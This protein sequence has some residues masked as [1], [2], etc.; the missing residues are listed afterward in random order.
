MAIEIINSSNQTIQLTSELQSKN[1]NK[2][3]TGFKI[4][5]NTDA[6]SLSI[7]HKN[8]DVVSENAAASMSDIN[9]IDKADALVEEAKKRILSNPQESV[10]AQANQAGSGV[11]NLIK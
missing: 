10:L 4:N 7:K 2:L 11:M 3:S 1:T 9:D 5:R 6:A 8:T